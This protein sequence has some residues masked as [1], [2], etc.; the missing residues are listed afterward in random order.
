MY[1]QYH[2]LAVPRDISG[3]TGSDVTDKFQRFTTEQIA[4]FQSLCKLR[5]DG[6]CDVS[7][8][9]VSAVSVLITTYCD[10]SAL[11]SAVSVLTTT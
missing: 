8:A 7:A 2:F 9:L 6:H 3:W 10:V 4:V 5:L 11:I 1:L